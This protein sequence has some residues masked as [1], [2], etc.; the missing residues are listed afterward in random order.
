MVIPYLKVFFHI[1]YRNF[2]IMKT[3][4]FIAI[5]VFAVISIFSL[6]ACMSDPDLENYPEVSF[7]NEVMLIISSNCNQPGCHGGVETE[8]FSMTSY[9]EVMVHV[10]AGNGRKSNLY[11]VITGREDKI[12]PP[13]P[14]NLLTEEQIRTIFVWI[15]QGAPNN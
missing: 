9:E 11:R 14:L 2:M 3:R 7:S 8:E 12:M 1:C 4:I 13:E 15:E 5:C 6:P 10:K